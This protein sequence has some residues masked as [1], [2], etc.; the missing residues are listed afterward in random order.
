MA[1][2]TICTMAS[3][4]AAERTGKEIWRLKCFAFI[5]GAWGLSLGGSW[6]LMNSQVAPLGGALHILLAAFAISVS[7]RVELLKALLWVGCGFACAAA[8]LYSLLMALSAFGIFG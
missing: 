3:V 5:L 1:T 2:A 8:L 7:L 6:W 4:H